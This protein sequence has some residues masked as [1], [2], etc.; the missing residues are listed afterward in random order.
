MTK[1]ELPD[2]TTQRI[3]TKLDALRR[4]RDEFVAQANREIA[5]RN[6]QIAALEALLKPEEPASPE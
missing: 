1:V 6:G 4:E 5:Y 2:I 3:T